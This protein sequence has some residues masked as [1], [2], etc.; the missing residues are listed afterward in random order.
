MQFVATKN[1]FHKGLQIVSTIA[2]KNAHL[3][4][5]NHVYISTEDKELKLVTTNLEI[6]VVAHVRAAVDTVGTFTVPAK[7][8]FDYVNLLQGDN[9]ECTLAE[10]ELK[11]KGGRSTTKIKGAPATDFPLIPPVEATKTFTVDPRELAVG[12]TQ[13]VYAASHNE[14]R[15]ELGG[16]L[17]S[18]NP[19]GISEMLI[20]AAT[21][22]YR[23]AEK[24]IP[25][26]GSGESARLIV[27]VRA[28]MEVMRIIAAL[29]GD[30]LAP[31]MDIHIGERQI[32]FVMEGV[33]LTSRLVDGSYPD[34]TQIIPQ[35]FGTK[36][37]VSRDQIINAVKAASLF[38]TTG[39][40]AV[41]LHIEAERKVLTVASM[42]TQLGEHTSEIEAEITGNEASIVLNFRYVLDALST[43]SAAQMELGVVSADA[44]C[45]VRGVGDDTVLAIIMPIRQ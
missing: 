13:V 4:I 11:V 16:V 33:G 10:N 35:K 12:L 9:V 30:D 31:T 22:S 19:E 41:S 38:S 27:P 24:K 1:N 8:I 25:V 3:P 40:N 14:V 34:Y 21:D 37:V 28:C 45:V 36:A 20:L 17:F 15:P 26:K 2:Q 39:I 23:L 42:S 6:A 32:K 5:L 7:T 43:I 29:R 18:F 44:P